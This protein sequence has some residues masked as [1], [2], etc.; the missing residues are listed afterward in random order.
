MRLNHTVWTKRAVTGAV[1]SERAASQPCFTPRFVHSRQRRNA[2]P[3]K[4]VIT[5]K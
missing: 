2:Q 1:F 3:A 5:E 4:G